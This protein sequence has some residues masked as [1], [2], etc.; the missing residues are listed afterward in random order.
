MMDKIYLFINILLTVIV[1][2]I[3]LQ[4]TPTLISSNEDVQ[5]YTGIGILLVGLTFVCWKGI[6][7]FETFKK[8]EK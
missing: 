8:E 6:E 5:F 7:I 2:I 4:V 1:A 3:V